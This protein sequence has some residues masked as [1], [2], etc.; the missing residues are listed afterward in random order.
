MKKLL[1][2]LLL[3][4]LL[5]ASPVAMSTNA[6]A[7]EHVCYDRSNMIDTLINTYGEQL[8]E[9]HAIKNRGLLE[10]HV[11]PSDGTWT[12]LLTDIDGQSCVLASGEGL[13]PS[14]LLLI[15]LGHQI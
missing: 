12:A 10:F 14:K 2:L 7:E 11:S 15:E 9:A 8:A 6:M 5:V 13:D 1:R 3:P 4:L